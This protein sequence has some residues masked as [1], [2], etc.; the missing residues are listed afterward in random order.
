LE[1]SLSDLLPVVAAVDLEGFEKSE[2]GHS[3]VSQETGGFLNCKDEEGDGFFRYRH[4]GMT[5]GGIH[6]LETW[7]RAEGSGVFQDILLVRIESD[8]VIEEGRA[9][10]RTVMR[11]VGRFT[12]G[13][14]D[15]G[16]IHLEGDRL[17]IGK[18]RYRN[19]DTVLSLN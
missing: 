13:D 1:T 18:S 12:L 11:S 3:P 8:N 6:V 5:P 17:M 7:E 19:A 16:S 15:D 14:R 4:I 2:E 10:T 9:R